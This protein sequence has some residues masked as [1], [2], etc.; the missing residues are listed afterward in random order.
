MPGWFPPAG[1]GD[2]NFAGSATAA[3][4]KHLFGVIRTAL[5]AV[6]QLRPHALQECEVSDAVG[7][8][9]AKRTAS[10]SSK[11]PRW[12]ADG[13]TGSRSTAGLCSPST[14]AQAAGGGTPVEPE[15][16]SPIDIDAMGA[17][18]EPA[19]AEEEAAGDG[20]AESAGAGVVAAALRATGKSRSLPCVVCRQLVSVQAEEKHMRE[21]HGC[22]QVVT[23]K[24][25]SLADA[26]VLLEAVGACTSNSYSCRD[27]ESLPARKGQP[28]LGRQVYYC[29]SSYH[30]AASLDRLAEARTAPDAAA[31]A[32]ASAGSISVAADTGTLKQ[33]RQHMRG[34][35]MDGLKTL[36]GTLHCPAK[37]WITGPRHAESASEVQKQKKKVNATAA[38]AEKGAQHREAKPSLLDRHVRGTDLFTVTVS[39]A[40]SHPGTAFFLGVS[41][42]SAFA[43]VLAA[44]ALKDSPNPVSADVARHWATQC[45]QEFGDMADSLAVK[46]KV[47]ENAIWRVRDL[48]K[49]KLKVKPDAV[50]LMEEI[51]TFAGVAHMVKA[52]KLPGN[53]Y[54]FTPPDPALVAAAVSA[55]AGAGAGAGS[56]CRSRH[57][58][59]QDNDI[60]ICIVN[61]DKLSVLAECDVVA[62]DHVFGV[63]ASFKQLAV[64]MIMAVDRAGKAH[65][66][67]TGIVS[68]KG[69]TMTAAVLH[70]VAEAARQ[71]GINWQP[72]HLLHDITVT[73][74]MGAKTALPSLR[75]SLYCHWHRI[76][77]CSKHV[78]E[79]VD[80]VVDP[81]LL[82]AIEG[83]KLT[84]TQALS[85]QRNMVYAMLVATWASANQNACAA[86][87]VMTAHYALA[88][89]KLESWLANKFHN[90][91]G[92]KQ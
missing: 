58:A 88:Y 65:S 84:P 22:G 78:N 6:S 1:S 74:F 64:L 51:Q 52:I 62:V 83:N 91:C 33:Q 24:C 89:P 66:I 5:A 45:W 17:G 19:A 56:A 23:F 50:L 38:V 4:V 13:F 92:T 3:A 63:E 47:I 86:T 53:T 85:Y 34:L 39:T 32:A 27:S 70:E 79:C 37:A 72:T 90:N 57:C 29:S 81:C 11:V 87:A 40:H 80:H 20:D 46:A 14:A 41:C 75:V 44:A 48:R 42:M 26:E 25:D 67:A 36:H 10:G 43:D 18:S 82:Q 77:A 54:T 59:L 7:R 12:D 15:D 30:D 31:A 9:A 73:D 69:A 8:G 76:A 49:E 35:D 55:A 16:V 21:E 60:M 68:D 28:L 61:P 71:R 2:F